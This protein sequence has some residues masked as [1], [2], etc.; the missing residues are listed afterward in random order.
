MIKQVHLKH[1]KSQISF[2][3]GSHHF[4]INKYSSA[5]I[6]SFSFFFFPHQK[7]NGLFFFQILKAFF[8]SISN[9]RWRYKE[10]KKPYANFIKHHF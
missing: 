8:P 10:E 1:Q 5:F 2:S 9:G 7:S 4:K 6:F 3:P